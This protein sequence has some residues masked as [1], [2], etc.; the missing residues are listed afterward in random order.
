MPKEVNFMSSTR[1][2]VLNQLAQTVTNTAGVVSGY[3]AKRN[4]IQ[5]QNSQGNGNRFS[6]AIKKPETQRPG[7]F[8]GRKSTVEKQEDS[9]LVD[10]LH[11]MDLKLKK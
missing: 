8:A 11:F 3:L 4:S 1:N 9:E 10:M 6:F 5:S 7:S 2:S